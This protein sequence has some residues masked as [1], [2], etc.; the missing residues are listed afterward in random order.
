MTAA[1]RSTADSY[2]E[3]LSDGSAEGLAEGVAGYASPCRPVAVASDPGGQ[4]ESL[5]ALEV[6]LAPNAVQHQGQPSTARYNLMQM[7]G[8]RQLA[9]PQKGGGASEALLALLRESDVLDECAPCNL[10]HARKLARFL[11]VNGCSRNETLD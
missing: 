6:R 3:G 2:T 7:L 11:Q 8:E 1:P 4:V 5:A 9:T 10:S